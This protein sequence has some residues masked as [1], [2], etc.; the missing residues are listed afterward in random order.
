MF[1]FNYNNSPM[2]SFSPFNLNNNHLQNETYGFN[3]NRSFYN[4]LQLQQYHSS[5]SAMADSFASSGYA[6]ANSSY[7]V[8]PAFNSNFNHVYQH[9]QLYETSSPRFTVSLSYLIKK[10]ILFFLN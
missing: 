3:D 4:N 10:K 1:Q 6:S 5:P 8:S 7:N 9:Q 2:T